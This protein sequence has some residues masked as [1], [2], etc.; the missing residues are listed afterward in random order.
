[1]DDAVVGLP[2]DASLD[3]SEAARASHR[4]P[5]GVKPPRSSRKER[6]AKDTAQ[7]SSGRHRRL[8]PNRPFWQELPILIIVA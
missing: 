5:K 8:M 2:T 4:A 3:A 7:A 1:M 6:K